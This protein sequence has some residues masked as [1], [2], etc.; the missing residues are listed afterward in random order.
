[1]AEVTI[2]D[3]RNHGGRVLERVM[4]GEALTVTRDGL[5]IAELRPLPRQPVGAAT[6]LNRWHR[7]PAVDAA[8]LRSDIDATLDASL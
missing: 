6:L 3:L 1:M 4:K 7:L 8:R 5:P 2:R